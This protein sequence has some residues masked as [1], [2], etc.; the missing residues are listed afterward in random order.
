MKVS[1]KSFDVQMEV[2]TKGIELEVRRPDDK[3]LGD[4]FVTKT[5][6]IWCKGKKKRRN[7]KK[8]SWVDFI[9]L[10]EG[11]EA[12][13]ARKRRRRTQTDRAA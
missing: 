10:I 7:G 2:K 11:N 6:V 3:H 1:I 12:K 8:V 5:S 9:K 13:P 4:V